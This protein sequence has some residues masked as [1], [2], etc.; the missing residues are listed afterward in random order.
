MSPVARDPTRASG[1][2]PRQNGVINLIAAVLIVVAL[3]LGAG[4]LS[5]HGLLATA[6]RVAA[7]LT[8]LTGL[9]IG[10]QALGWVIGLDAT[11]TKWIQS[12]G[13]HEFNWV[14]WVVTRLSSP[15]STAAIGLICAALISWRARS[16]VRGVVVIGT[17]VSAFLVETILKA[18]VARPPT[19]QELRSLN[20]YFYPDSHSFPS[21]HVAAVGALLGIVAVCAGRGRS[22]TTSAVL[23]G[24]VVAAVLLLAV[25]RVYIGAHWLSDV[26]GGAVVAALFVT[27]GAAAIN[28]FRA[29]PRNREGTQA[30]S[31]SAAPAATR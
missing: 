29:R 20:D 31:G 16:V 23:T 15:P 3:F 22:R 9:T 14:A 8:A 25:V 1:A 21:G 2:R 4:S 18:M 12:H 13:S 19:A 11:T 7:L 10:V 30:R 6:L 5:A 26:V 17:V 28:A 24:L 27:L